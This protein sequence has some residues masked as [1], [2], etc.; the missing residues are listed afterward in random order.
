MVKRKKSEKELKD[1]EPRAQFV[2]K[3]LQMV[4][5]HPNGARCQNCRKLSVSAR[6]TTHGPFQRTNRA[7]WNMKGA[8][9]RCIKVEVSRR[10]CQ[11][12]L[13]CYNGD[14]AIMIMRMHPGRDGDA[15]LTG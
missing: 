5:S 11:L 15:R 2:K 8:R 6:A 12:R 13:A 10:T 7:V 9:I 3:A 4:E 1:Q 14:F